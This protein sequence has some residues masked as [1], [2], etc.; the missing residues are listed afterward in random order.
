MPLH[1]G[2]DRAVSEI[3]AMK[4]PRTDQVVVW[5]LSTADEARMNEYLLPLRAP[6]SKTVSS[7]SVL[8]WY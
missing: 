6:L 8:C 3:E 2:K 5:F 4:R 7:S 1:P